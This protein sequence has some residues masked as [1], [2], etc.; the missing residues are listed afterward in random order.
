HARHH[1]SNRPLARVSCP[2]AADANVDLAKGPEVNV[3]CRTAYHWLLVSRCSDEMPKAL[4]RHVADC[5]RCRRRYRKLVRLEEHFKTE[6]PREDGMA[7]FLDRIGDLP[8]HEPASV[9]VGTSFSRRAFLGWAASIL[10]LIGLIGLFFQLRQ[11]NE[12][13]TPKSA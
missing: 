5:A 4:C 2:A 7:V 6:S 8:S 13:P 1:R 11:P 12:D 10:L 9:P 3:K